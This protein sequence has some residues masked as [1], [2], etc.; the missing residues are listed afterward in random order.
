MLQ[1]IVAVG[2]FTLGFPTCAVL[3]I[4]AGVNGVGRSMIHAGRELSEIGPWLAAVEPTT[5]LLDRVSRKAAPASRRLLKERTCRI[6][7]RSEPR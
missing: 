6:V 3:A 5:A 7:R 4:G 1:L 2:A